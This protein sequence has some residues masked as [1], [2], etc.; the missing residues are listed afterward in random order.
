M[1]DVSAP[2]GRPA[3]RR[4]R[5]RAVGVFLVL[6][7]L[8]LGFA[9]AAHAAA[10]AI[11][12]VTV[13]NLQAA[14][15]TI[16]WTTDVPADTRADYGLTA[17][18]GISTPTD[19][20]LVTAHSRTVTG[21]TGNQRYFFQVVSRSQAGE[22]ATSGGRTFITALGATTAGSSNDTSDSNG[23]DATR[24]TTAFGG[25][26]AALSVNVG[27]V[28]TQ[29]ANRAFQLAIYSANGNVPGA[30]VANTGTGVLV[31]NSWN[32][33]PLTADVTLAPN[34]PYFLAYNTNGRSSTVNNM[35]Y[36]SGGASA[37]RTA[38]QPFGTWPTTFGSATTQNVTFSLYATFVSDTTAP[39]VA[40]TSPADGASVT[41]T[42]TVTA[43]AAD[44][45]G[46]ASVR[47]RLGDTDL[48]APDTSEPYS[49]SWDTTALLDGPQTLTAVA[50]DGAGNTRTSAAVTV[51]TANP[52]RV[53]L[54]RPTAGEDIASTTVTATYRKAGDWAAGD[55]RH[56][57]FR[58]DGGATRMDFDTDGDARYDITGVPGGS[59]AL[60]YVVADGNHV[61]QSGSGGS[62]AFSTTAPD[63]S[64][65]ATAVTAP[66]AGA[67]LTGS[68]TVT[69]DA[70]DDVGVRG[71]QFLLDGTA[72][73]AE[74]TTAP[75]S[76]AWDTRTATNGAHLL[77]ARAR[78]VVN[79]TTSEPVSVTVANT[80]PR[81][82]LGDW[83]PV[84]DW[85]L[86]AVHATM[87]YTGEILMW[88]AWEA[89]NTDAKLW[90][91]AT[92]V[93]TD[94]PLTI[95]SS[96]LFCAGQAAGATGQLV[97]M[98]GHSTGSTVGTKGSRR[99]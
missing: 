40:I 86:V 33:I 28:D 47:F 78:D 69:A 31:G 14:S 80:D 92:N 43:G 82:T 42:T 11:T 16:T 2:P 25:K 96:E 88:D 21:L 68:V 24:F 12:S 41:G 74:D 54:I 27:A 89:P 51:R 3:K 58:L 98:G 65:P 59:H 18:L 32:T 4:R 83:G 79:Q 38:G 77:T 91:P 30:L 1:P 23:I 93:W 9:P 22:V 35:R 53:I 19:S 8:A 90:N 61:E 39:T 73:G 46:V 97:V 10:P 17:G 64:P 13:G 55:G 36:V 66:S 94:V 67:S 37:W 20:T 95:P 71:V 44:D 75:Y 49:T 81:A 72:L 6:A 34:T 76:A 99:N 56:V 15:V 50:T 5:A 62:V 7:L 60:D 52:A 87:L 29:V 57:H 63:A 45:T 85:P 84:M 48:G 26:V 70:T